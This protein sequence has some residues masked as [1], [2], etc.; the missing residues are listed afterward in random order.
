MM[1]DIIDTVKGEFQACDVKALDYFMDDCGIRNDRVNKSLN[2]IQKIV[3]VR[4]HFLNGT[5]N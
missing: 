1:D 3:T 5:E 2:D 4:R